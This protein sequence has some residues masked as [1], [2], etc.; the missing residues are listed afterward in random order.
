EEF[1]ANK[2]IFVRKETIGDIVKYSLEEK[3]IFTIHGHLSKTPEK[4]IQCD[5][6]F[7]A[8]STPVESFRTY[9][10]PCYDYITSLSTDSNSLSKYALDF[11]SF[12]RN[13]GL[14]F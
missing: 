3:V 11:F 1:F 2:D 10:Y 6:N 14:R 12:A 7:V 4:L 5:L 13:Y 8:F 9:D